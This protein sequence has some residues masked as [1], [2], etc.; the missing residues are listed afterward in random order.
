ME[1]HS[2]AAKNRSR[3]ELGEAEVRGQ[4]SRTHFAGMKI[5]LKVMRR[6]QTFTAFL[7]LKPT[8]ESISHLFRGRGHLSPREPPRD[9]NHLLFKDSFSSGNHMGPNRGCVPGDR[10]T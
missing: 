9:S 5:G 3:A 6:G 7:H 10:L 2:V 1:L 8:P 4:C